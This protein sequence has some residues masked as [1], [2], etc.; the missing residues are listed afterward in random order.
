MD[1]ITMLILMACPLDFLQVPS[2]QLSISERVDL[3]MVLSYS[4]R[5]TQNFQKAQALM[6]EIRKQSQSHDQLMKHLESAM[7]LAFHYL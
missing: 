1:S 7:Q 2:F 5:L 6:E 4:Y 3:Q